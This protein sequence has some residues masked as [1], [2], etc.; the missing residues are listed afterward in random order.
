MA[1]N[2]N[3]TIGSPPLLWSEVQAAFTKINE[4]FDI[5]STLTG[6]GTLNFETLDTSVKPTT[7]NLYDLGD[8]T[9]KWR[10]VYAGEHTLTDP[11][12]GLWAGNAQIKGIGY[13]VNLP[14][15]STIGGDPLTGIGAELIIDPDKTFFKEIQVDNNLSVV[16]TSFGDTINLLSGSGISLTVNSG[17]DSIEI[18]NTGILTVT[19]GLG[20]SVST[21]SGTSTVTN[22]GVRS[23]TSTTALPSGRTAGLGINIDSSTGD[24]IKITN[25]GVISISNGVGITISTDSATGVVTVTN[26][27]PASNTFA[28]VEVNGDSANRLVA[29]AAADILNI[30]SGLGIT[31][32]KTVATD[33]LNIAVSPVFD[34]KGSVFG[35][36]SS[37]LVDA[38][39]NYIY[40]NVSATTLR[41]AETK[42]ALGADAGTVSQGTNA[43]AIGNLAGETSQGLRG[44]AVGFQAAGI[45]QGARAIAIGQSAGYNT[46]GANGIAIGESSGQ[47]NQGADAIAIGRTAGVTNQSANSIILNASGSTLNAA[48]AGFFVNPIRSTA[49]GRPLM[50]D[51]ATKELFSSNVLEF[52]GS[53]ISTS[54]SSA[55]KFDSAVNFETDIAAESNIVLKDGLYARDGTTLLIDGVSGK[56]VGDLNGNITRTTTLTITAPDIHIVGTMYGDV[57]DVSSLAASV[58]LSGTGVITGNIIYANPLSAQ[59]LIFPSATIVPGRRF[60]I[61]NGNGSSTITVKDSLAA[62]ITTVGPNTAKEIFSDSFSWVV[63]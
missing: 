49:N 3:I 23:L 13:T 60:V 20:M 39:S 40:G 45:S 62:T 36:D 29:D 55:I 30:T 6:I 14:A 26:S 22:S 54:D 57:Q 41:T 52:I 42:I 51:T 44:V 61:S 9:H 34:L 15:N 1:Y 33:T 5:I 7:D 37:I 27:A 35:D 43:V 47:T 28:Q 12:N 56:L 63:L 16:A 32:S 58:D 11:L 4:N 46:Q 10:G 2:T 53:T 48:A 8:I 25:T 21:V 31:L 18:D 24:G 59:D 50:Y 38:V 17:A 19:A